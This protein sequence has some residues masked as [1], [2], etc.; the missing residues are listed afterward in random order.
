MKKLIMFILL[1]IVTS[2]ITF[3]Q[4]AKELAKERFNGNDV[5]LED[6]DIIA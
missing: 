1:S 4:S 3:A 5:Q 6:E 2:G